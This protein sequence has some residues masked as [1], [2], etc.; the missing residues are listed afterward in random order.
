MAAQHAGRDAMVGTLRALPVLDAAY[1]HWMNTY[2]GM[3]EQVGALPS[4]GELY[5]GFRRLLAARPGER[6]AA[7][8]AERRPSRPHR[9]DSH[10]PTA[11]RI[12]LIEKLPADGRPDGAGR[13]GRARPAA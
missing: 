8:S 5:G 6:L 1:D 7:I 3:G 4:V 13:A 9:Y 11:E 10:P 2:A 12:A